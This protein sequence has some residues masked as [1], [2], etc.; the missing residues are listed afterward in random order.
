LLTNKKLLRFFAKKSIKCGVN[1]Q[2]KSVIKPTPRLR[3][4]DFPLAGNDY[5]PNG[6]G[7]SRIILTANGR[8][9]LGYGDNGAIYAWNGGERYLL[10][11]KQSVE[12]K[13]ILE[14]E[15]SLAGTVVFTDL[16]NYPAW[17]KLVWEALP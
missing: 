13:I 5:P 8:M 4:T 17:L 9:G 10:T 6:A 12:F 16:D 1:D 15:G 7:L 3:L 11:L 14:Y 2:K